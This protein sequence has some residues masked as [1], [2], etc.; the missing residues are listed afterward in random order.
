M[1]QLGPTL[2]R[3]REARGLT[4]A[5]LAR[6]AGLVQSAISMIEAGKRPNPGG[7]TLYKLAK[8][9]AVPMSDLLDPAPVEAVA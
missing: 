9:L 6:K 3:L 7:A 5:Q 8:A 2:T 4:Q 1:E